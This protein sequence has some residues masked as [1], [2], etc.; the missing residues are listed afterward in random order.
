[1]IKHKPQSTKIERSISKL[2]KSLFKSLAN[3]AKDWIS[4]LSPS[5]QI[6]TLI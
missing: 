6:K 3:I 2:V 1:M 5:N 4:K